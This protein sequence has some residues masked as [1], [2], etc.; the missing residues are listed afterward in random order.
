MGTAWRGVVQTTCRP[1]GRLVYDAPMKTVGAFEAKT[2]LAELLDLVEAG[3]RVTI[4]RRG[5]PVAM[6][7]PVRE[8]PA[9][10]SDEA[11]AALR[12]LRRGVTLGDVSVRQLIDEGR[13]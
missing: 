8:E 12:E 3:E 6:L 4:T 1:V 13:P 10:T 5:D 7:V 9:M 11:V 2:H